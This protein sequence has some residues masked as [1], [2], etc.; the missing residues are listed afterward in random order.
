[1]TPHSSVAFG[2]GWPHVPTPSHSSNLQNFIIAK[3]F[4]GWRLVPLA[5][6]NLTI[7]HSNVEGVI[8]QVILEDSVVGRAG[9]KRWGRINLKRQHNVTLTRDPDTDKPH[10]DT[11]T[12]HSPA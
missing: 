4:L 1:M 2:R 10:E 9:G 3:H 8:D 12:E 7:R 11:M 6:W 5:V